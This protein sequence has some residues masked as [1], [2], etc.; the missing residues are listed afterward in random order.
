M[1]PLDVWL[2]QDR[3]YFQGDVHEWI[4]EY[5]RRLGHAY[6][7]ARNTCLIAGVW[8]P[9]WVKTDYSQANWCILGTHSFPVGIRFGMWGFLPHRRS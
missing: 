5:Q 3:D 6:S 2:G 4:E 8:G 1:V 7:Q 9:Q